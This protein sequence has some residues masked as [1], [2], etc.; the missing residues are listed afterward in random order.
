[1]KG[2]DTKE[3]KEFCNHIIIRQ[4][5]YTEISDS[6]VKVTDADINDYV[7]GIKTC[8]KQGRRP[9]YF[10]YIFQFTGKFGR[11]R[12]CTEFFERTQGLL[13]GRFQT[14]A[15][16]SRNA[17]AIDFSDDYQPK[18]KISSSVADTLTKLSPGAVFGLTRI[19]K[20]CAG[21]NARQQII[22]RQR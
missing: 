8:S 5:P 22:P 7:S 13:P 1:M 4:H 21:Q 10:L 16:L 14:R 12:P 19:R 17:S 11:Q 18:S 2:K 3:A 6:T 15:L 20:F 9:L